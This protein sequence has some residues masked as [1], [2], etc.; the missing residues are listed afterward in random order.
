MSQLAQAI[1]DAITKLR[2]YEMQ[3]WHQST[4][5][6]WWGEGVEIETI[7]NAGAEQHG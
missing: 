5:L 1:D 7:M 6:F 2:R 4:V 3:G